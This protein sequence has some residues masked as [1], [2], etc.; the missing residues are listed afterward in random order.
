VNDQAAAGF[1]A[2]PAPGAT[3]TEGSRTAASVLALPVSPQ[4]SRPISPPCVSRPHF[5]RSG[6]FPSA[7]YFFFFF[8]AFLAFLFFAITGLHRKL[9]KESTKPVHAA[10]VYP[11]AG[12]TPVEPNPFASR[13]WERAA[14]KKNFR[15]IF[16]DHRKNISAAL[17]I[18]RKAA[19][20]ISRQNGAKQAASVEF[21]MHSIAIIT[22]NRHGFDNLASLRL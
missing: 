8:V 19:R 17:H 12:I 13:H 2:G 15:S 3:A 22:G 9:R 16:R 6:G 10:T 18:I 4:L 14:W 5:R 21:E 20:I 11:V 7:I 1:G